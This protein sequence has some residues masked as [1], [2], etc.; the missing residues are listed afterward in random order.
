MIIAFA[1]PKGAEAAVKGEFL[2]KGVRL[3]VKIRLNVRL[4]WGLM[5]VV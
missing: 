1:N 5:V 4:R 3:S 2:D